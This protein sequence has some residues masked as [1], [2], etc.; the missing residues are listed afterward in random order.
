MPTLASLLLGP[1][2]RTLAIAESI[3]VGRIQARVGAISGSSKFFLG[4][5]TAYTLEQKVRHLGID[6]ALAEP[7]YSVSAEIAQQMAAGVCRLFGADV[8]VATTGFAEPWP[9]RAVAQPYAWWATAV[10]GP[11]GTFRLARGRVD[12]PGASRAE[13]QERV[14]EAAWE[15]LLASLR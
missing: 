4:G 15:A 3:T 11:E 8:G 10:R 1:P 14:T 6:R 7:V 12:C 13:A 2:L 9:E 5:I